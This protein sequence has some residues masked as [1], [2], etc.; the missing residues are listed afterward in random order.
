MFWGRMA[1]GLILAAGA[2]FALGPRERAVLG[3]V[4]GAVPVAL[5]DTPGEWLAQ[6][7]Q[8][9]R[10]EV[11]SYLQWA[12][13]P[14]QQADIAIIYVHGFSASPAE[15]RP[16]P[17]DLARQLGAN[18]LAVRLTGHGQDGRDLAQA[19][20]QDWWR[21]LAQALS[22]GRQMGRK[23]VVLGMSTGAT[24]VAEAA[25]DPQL[26]AQFDAAILLSPNF[27]MRNKWA[28]ALR[29]PWMRQVL[30]A[31]GQPE[32]CFEPRNDLHAARWTSCYPISATLPVAALNARSLRGDFTKAKVPAL[33][34]WAE[35]DRVVDH[36]VTGRIA[37]IWGREVQTLIV[38]PGPL[39]DPAGH[40][41]AGDALSPA[42]N[43]TLMQ[44]MS[45][46][47]GKTLG[48]NVKEK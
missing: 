30:S 47:I 40:V 23:V 27:R 33:F 14:G 39:D 26:S 20:A 34:V 36:G 38:E 35:K 37:M 48:Q 4:L 18:L 43:V 29:L 28:W 31:I 32:R 44:A 24:L 11:A 21:D 17:E 41:I 2:V 5:P 46:W 8:G 1:L 13:R 15:L 3:P 16:L 10:A 25:R 22:Y 12:E 6:R 7:E 9:I 45:D 42:M 19:R